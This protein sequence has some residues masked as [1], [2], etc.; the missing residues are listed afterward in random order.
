MNIKI[1]KKYIY[2]NEIVLYSY[3]PFSVQ[4]SH[5]KVQR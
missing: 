2:M 1:V 3:F 5:L 4:F